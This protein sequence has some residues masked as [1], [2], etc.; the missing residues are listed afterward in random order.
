VTAL[1]HGILMIPDDMQWDPDDWDPSDRPLIIPEQFSTSI[2]FHSIDPE[3]YTILTG[4][5]IPIAYQWLD[6]QGEN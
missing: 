3:V 2:T 1:G 4:E 5:G 6:G